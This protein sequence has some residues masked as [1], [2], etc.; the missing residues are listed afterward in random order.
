MKKYEAA[1][2]TAVLGHGEGRGGVGK[3]WPL[4]PLPPAVLPAAGPPPAGCAPSRRPGAL[5]IPCPQ[6]SVS[7][8]PHHGLCILLPHAH[9]SLP[10]SVVSPS[11]KLSSHQLSLFLLGLLIVNCLAFSP[12]SEIRKYQEVLVLH[13]PQE[14]LG[15]GFAHRHVSNDDTTSVP[16]T[17]CL[18]HQCLSP[19]S[20]WPLEPDNGRVNLSCRT[21]YGPWSSPFLILEFPYV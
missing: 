14:A 3:G 5:L 21:G 7:S 2:G 11:L 18:S 20:Q 6:P 8:L 4:A 17:Q 1:E 16:T 12:T 19:L 10:Q 9:H 15:Q 13:G